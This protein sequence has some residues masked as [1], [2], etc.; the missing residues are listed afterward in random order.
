MRSPR[1]TPLILVSRSSSRSRRSSSPSA[2]APARSA[3]AMWYTWTSTAPR[4][5]STSNCATTQSKSARCASSTSPPSEKEDASPKCQTHRR[6]A[7]A[8]TAGSSR[9]L[10]WSSSGHCQT[11]RT[12]GARLLPTP[13][14][15]HHAQPVVLRMSSGRYRLRKTTPAKLVQPDGHRPAAM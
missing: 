1:S 2:S 10:A 3:V 5:V 6:C 7:T 9:E 8:T 12:T 4:A 15:D 13:M 14:P 11:S